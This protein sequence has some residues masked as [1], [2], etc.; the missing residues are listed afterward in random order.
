[1]NKSSLLLKIIF[2][3][4]KNFKIKLQNNTQKLFTKYIKMES[5]IACI[6]QKR[7]MRVNWL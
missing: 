4:Y 1:L 3:N 6:N 5:L 7:E 2:Q